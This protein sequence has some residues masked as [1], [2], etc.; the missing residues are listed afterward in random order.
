M[1]GFFCVMS[2]SHWTLWWLI[3]TKL[4]HINFGVIQGFPALRKAETTHVKKYDI[5]SRM[6]KQNTKR[7]TEG[8]EFSGFGNGISRSWERKLKTGGFATG[9]LWP[10]TK[11]I[12]SVAKDQFNSWKFSV[13]KIR[14]F[15]FVVIQLFYLECTKHLL[16]FIRGLSILWFSFIN[17]V[18]FSCQ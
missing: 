17:K 6:W 10:F 5:F 7:K 16:I 11:K 3:F 18:D 9:R 4:R 1:T 13:L 15:I 12:S 8:Y 2:H 14:P